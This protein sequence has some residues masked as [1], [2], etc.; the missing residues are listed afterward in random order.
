MQ[1]MS[2][3]RFEVVTLDSLGLRRMH[4]GY[5]TDE[6]IPRSH[7]SDTPYPLPGSA[8]VCLICPRVPQNILFGKK[9]SVARK[10]FKTLRWAIE[11]RKSYKK[12][13]GAFGLVFQKDHFGTRED[14]VLYLL[15]ISSQG[16]FVLLGQPLA[17]ILSSFLQASGTETYPA[18]WSFC[19]LP[20]WLWILK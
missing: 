1:S 13:I 11:F 7:I 8:F 19:S 18:P 3:S 12:E 9:Y 2:Q 16:C 15:L 6:H 5:H 14:K 4:Q 20:D 17:L 10:S